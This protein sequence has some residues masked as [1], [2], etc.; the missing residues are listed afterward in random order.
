[1]LFLIFYFS[2]VFVLI[3]HV[4][5]FITFFFFLFH[6]FILDF[7]LVIQLSNQRIVQYAYFFVNLRYW[8][9]HIKCFKYLHSLEYFKIFIIRILDLHEVVNLRLEL[10]LIISFFYLVFVSFILAIFF[11]F[12]A[13][14]SRVHLLSFINFINLLII[15]HQFIHLNFN[16]IHVFEI[17]VISLF[18]N[19]GFYFYIQPILFFLST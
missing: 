1:M 12:E 18:F 16:L 11:V 6:T 13:S 2:F 10:L 4:Q 3:W 9:Q 8:V 19:R 5:F 15:L 14:I 7:I 17:F